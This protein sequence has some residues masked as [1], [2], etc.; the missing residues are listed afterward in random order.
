ML[1]SSV[2]VGEVAARLAAAS[3]RRNRTVCRSASRHQTSAA[4]HGCWSGTSAPRATTNGVPCGQATTSGTSG[5]GGVGR[6]AAAPW[7]AARVSRHSTGKAR[8]GTASGRGSGD[9]TQWVRNADGTGML[10]FAWIV[11]HAT[12]P[13]PLSL[14]QLP[15]QPPAKV[16]AP[17]QKPAAPAGGQKPA[18]AP[19]RPAAAPGMQYDPNTGWPIVAEASSQGSPTSNQPA[20]ANGLGKASGEPG[21]A[22]VGETRTAA[23]GS[24]VADTGS[25]AF[26]AF[27][28]PSRPQ[29]PGDEPK[30]ALV[31]GMQLGSPLLDVY[32]AVGSPG[33]LGD[34]GG[35]VVWWRLTTFG[36]Q[37]EQIGLREVTHTADLRFAERDRLEFQDGRIYGRVGAQV[38]AEL[39]GM[40]WPTL[41][42]AAAQDLMLFGLHLRMPWSFGDAKTWM[43]VGKDVE[44]RSGER[45]VHLTL[46]RVPPIALDVVGPELDPKPRDRFEL[47]CDPVEWA[48]ARAAA[49]LRLQPGDAARAARGLAR[50]RRRAHAVPPRLRRRGAAR[51]DDVGDPAR[52]TPAD[53]RARLPAALRS[54]AAAAAPVT[55]RRSAPSAAAPRP[56]PG[57][58]AS[59]R[60]AACGRRDR[61]AVRSG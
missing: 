36:E 50:G 35:V 11:L 24:K 32:Q 15:T 25:K 7:Q 8:T 59:C 28:P 16:A 53:D 49:P 10:S 12:A 48:A 1:S 18:G 54:G 41:N 3:S 55:W 22:P 52:R 56:R 4:R 2:G 47:L 9:S 19:P 60:R 40:P 51:Q 57:S 6:G 27:G 42:E 14:P 43:V 31:S 30:P 17:S 23:S 13:S 46:E 33:K 58:A 38:F 44:E 20:A 29:Q 61:P 37:G 34:L 39:R 21:A 5:R 45:F 26:A